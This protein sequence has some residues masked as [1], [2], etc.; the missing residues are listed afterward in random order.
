MKHLLLNL[1]RNRHFLYC[2]LATVLL[3][4]CG[5]DKRNNEAVK[6]ITESKK[7]IKVYKHKMNGWTY[8]YDYTLVDSIGKIYFT[9]EIELTLP[10]TI[11]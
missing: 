3:F 5:V 8:N 1:H 2:L 4:S 6:W 7:P 9:G 11:R 10:D